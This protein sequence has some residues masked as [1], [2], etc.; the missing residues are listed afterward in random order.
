MFADQPT[1]AKLVADAG[2]GLALAEGGGS[3]EVNT[4]ELFERLPLLATLVDEVL[5]EERFALAAR[6]LAVELGDADSPATLARR[7]A[8]DDL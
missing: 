5:R 6:G 2:A 8:T 7:L 4:R 1:N 3:A